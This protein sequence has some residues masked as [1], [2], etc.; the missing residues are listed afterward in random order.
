VES[1]DD[2]SR[3]PGPA[4]PEAD[5]WSTNSFNPNTFDPTSYMGV[6]SKTVLGPLAAPYRLQPP[7]AMTLEDP[8]LPSYNTGM[9]SGAAVFNDAT[10]HRN[11]YP[12]FNC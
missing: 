1:I 9:P 5:I 4:A 10:D 12:S 11:G 6:H 3:S 7:V 2:W 8:M